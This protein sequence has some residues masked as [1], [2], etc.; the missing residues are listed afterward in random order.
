[1]ALTLATLPMHCSSTTFGISIPLG[2]ASDAPARHFSLSVYSRFV[3]AP[4]PALLSFVSFSCSTKLTRHLMVAQDVSWRW[5][6]SAAFLVPPI[7]PLAIYRI[8]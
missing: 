3:I 8:A 1:M 4:I 2:G 5:L 7:L 6:C